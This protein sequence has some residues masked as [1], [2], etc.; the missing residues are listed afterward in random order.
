VLQAEA[1]LQE[2]YDQCGNS[3][4]YSQASNDGYINIRNRLS[5]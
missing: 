1:V 4:E 2:Q 3:T 5:T